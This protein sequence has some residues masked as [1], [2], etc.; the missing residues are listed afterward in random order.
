MVD[1]TGSNQRLVDKSAVVELRGTLSHQP[2]E[3]FGVNG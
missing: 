3:R 1:G 2:E